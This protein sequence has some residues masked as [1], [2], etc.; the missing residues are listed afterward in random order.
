V[1]I[2]LL[3]SLMLFSATM[4]S[5]ENI[6]QPEVVQVENVLVDAEM[7]TVYVGNANNQY[8]IY[9]NT[10]A[11]GCFTPEENKN[12]L[13]ITESTRWKMPGAT[14]FLTLA[15]LQ[16]F[17]VKYNRGENVALVPEDSNGEEGVF[18]RD[19]AD[20]GYEAN[21]IISDGPI[22]YGTGMSDADRQ[23]T[24][25]A[26]FMQMLEAAT[27]QQGKTVVAA[28]L[29]RRCLPGEDFCTV[30]LNANLVGVGGIQEPRKVD[31]L[32][33]TDVHDE[34]KQLSRL[35]CTHPAKGTVVCRDWMT[36]RLVSAKHADQ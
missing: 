35:V 5:A 12:Y 25:Q 16:G 9:C 29:A 22:A 7:R 36:G 20:G 19:P 21:I 32:V 26:F 1:K 6:V 23:R 33:S 27:K 18:V 10:E 2:A 13:L 34:N 15:F 28:K 3:A 4:A 8:L 17:F 14:E 24:W 30:I 31:L 11:K